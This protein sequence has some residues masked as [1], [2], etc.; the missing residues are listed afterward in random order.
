MFTR[1]CQKSHQCDFEQHTLSHQCDVL[2]ELQ[3]RAIDL[4][5]LGKTQEEVAA[6]IGVTRESI[7]R[8]L[9][10]NPAFIIAFNERCEQ[11]QVEAAELLRSLQEAVRLIEQVL[12]DTCCMENL[13]VKSAF[14]KI[15]TFFSYNDY[16]Q[17]VLSVK[18]LESA[19]RAR[20]AEA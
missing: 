19:G 17:L 11:M 6:E 2:S 8:W 1:N 15:K 14:N 5:L 16:K 3:Q 4:L 7:N 10:R 18:A 20:S 12:A 13:E 9:N